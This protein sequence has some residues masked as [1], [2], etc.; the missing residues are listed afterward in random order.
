VDKKFKYAANIVLGGALLF[1]GTN[2]GIKMIDYKKAENLYEDMRELTSGEEDEYTKQKNSYNKL[3]EINEDYVFW[4]NVENTNI[5]YPV[6]QTEDNDFYLTKD[7]NKSKSSSGTVFMDTLNNFLTD[8][9]VVLYGHNMN[10]KTM[11]NQI[12]KFKEKSFFEQNNKITIKNTNNG[13]EYIYEV[14]AVYSSDN[15]F[16][17]NTVVFSENYTFEQYISEIKERSLFKKSI[18]IS[19]KDKIITLSTCSYEFKGAKTSIHAKL[20]ET[21][22][23]NPNSLQNKDKETLEELENSISDDMSIKN[24]FEQ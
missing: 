5:D 2:L 16:N 10:N 19:A 12:N 24:M 9:N 21:K 4:V 18:D 11:F 17:Y 23:L 15:K 20:V 22:N 6:V 13:K 1:S 3:K 14:F 7:F 8:K